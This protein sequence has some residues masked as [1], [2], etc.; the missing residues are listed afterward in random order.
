MMQGSQP[1]PYLSSSWGR[2]MM[3]L[4]GASLARSTWA[5]YEA[6]WNCFADFETNRS[7]PS[8]WPIPAE[9]LRDFAVWGIRCRGLAPASLKTYFLAL[10]M[11]H[12]LKGLSFPGLEDKLLDLIIRGAEN[13]AAK[14]IPPPSS[15][16]QQARRAVSLPMLKILGHKLAESGW[17]PTSKQSIWTA[18]LVAFFSSARMGELLAKGE[19]GF[20][21][22]ST[23]LWGDIKAREDG[24]FLL[25][26]KSPKSR[27]A[28]GEFLD[29]FQFQGCCPAAALRQ[30]H[31]LWLS[32]S[33]D[34]PVFRLA[35]GINLTIWRLNK[36]LRDLVVGL[37]KIRPGDISCH[38]FRAGL[39]SHLARFPELASSSEIKQWG[40]WKGDSFQLYTRGEGTQRRK[41]FSTITA[42][43]NPM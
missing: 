32:P 33:K 31:Q 22:D 15:H 12:K 4:V 30:L 9:I 39:P 7:S 28:K 18:M 26:I 41:I 8:P 37:P 2:D 13:L 21:P 23:L 3:E 17:D 42:T 25:H 29:I 43:L 34:L 36:V 38:S 5:K 27:S 6:G 11:A 40:R 10:S 35:G 1:S 24:S 14:S 19:K 20:D 16:P